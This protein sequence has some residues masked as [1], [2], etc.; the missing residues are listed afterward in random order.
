MT[1]LVSVR[2]KIEQVAAM[3]TIADVAGRLQVTLTLDQAAEFL[4]LHAHTVQARAK[5]GIIPASKPGR[6]WVFLRADLEQYLRSLMGDKCR[7]TGA[8]KRGGS[9]SLITDSEYADLLRPGIARR[10][11]AST[12][13]SRRSSGNV[14]MFPARPG[15][16]P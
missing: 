4:K 15:A 5:A 16:R 6:R 8:V 12:T 11:S 3:L 2:T 1:R 13:S 10:R 7:S 9:T 14:A